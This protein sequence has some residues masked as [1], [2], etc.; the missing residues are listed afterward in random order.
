[1]L[2]RSVQILGHYSIRSIRKKNDYK[3]LQTQTRLPFQIN[4]K[5]SYFIFVAKGVVI[6]TECTLSRFADDPKLSGAGIR[7]EGKDARS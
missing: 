6:H 2:N 7:A 4:Q 3:L 5:E 1:M